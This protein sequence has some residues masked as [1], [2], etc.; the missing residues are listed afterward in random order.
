[1]P[2]VPP[3]LRASTPD[4]PD[5]PPLVQ[6]VVLRFR[7]A[8]LAWVETTLRRFVLLRCPAHPL[9]QIAQF[10]DPAPVVASC[11]AYYHADGTKGVP[12]TF[13]V[14]LLVRAEIV[15]SW[16]DSSSDRD[17][18]WHLISNLVV[19]WFVGLPL[20]SPAPDHSTLARLHAWLAIHHPDALFRDVL[21]FRDRVDP[22]AAATT[23]QIV[24]TLALQSPAAWS[25][26]VATLLLDL[27]ADLIVAWQHARASLQSAL[28]P[29]DFGPIIHPARPRDA[30]ERASLLVQAVILTQRLLAALTP[31][32]PAWPPEQRARITHLLSALAKVLADE[33]QLDASGYPTERT[34]KGDYRIISATD[35]EAT[36]RKH[37]DD[38]T[39]GYNV[40][41]ATTTTRIRAVVAVTGATPDNE[42]PILLA[43][44]QLLAQQP[45]PPYFIMDR[46]G[47]WGKCRARLD[48]VSNGQTQMVALIPPAGGA[49][50]TRFGPADF[51]VDPER[52]RCTCPNG[53]TS[54]KAYTRGDGDGVQFRFLASPCR[55]CPLW[56]DCCG[57][58]G[59]PKG[60]RSVFVSDDH[61]YL[62]QAAAFNQCVEGRALLASRWRVE[63]VIIERASRFEALGH[64]IALKG[65]GV[66]V[67]RQMGLESA[68]RARE[69]RFERS[70][71][72][73]AT[74]RLLRVGSQA[75]FDQNL[76]GYILFR[77][78]DLQAT[79]FEAVRDKLE[80]RY[81]TELVSLRDQGA[82]I[83]V[84][85]SVGTS[86][87]FDFVIGADG[88]HSRTRR[89]VFGDG[90]IEPLGGH[91][92]ALTV[93]FAHGLPANQVRSYFG[94][95]QS[96]HMFLTSPDH[97]STVVY[98]GAGGAQLAGKD[99]GSVKAF[100]LDAYN[101]FAPEVRAVF[102]AIDERAFVFVDAIGQVRMPS[103]VKGRVALIGDAAHCP[104]FMSGMGS[105]LALQGAQALA[106]HLEHQRDDP[107]RALR[108][109]QAAILPIAERYQASALEMRP[110]LLDRRPWLAWA[111]NAAL[112]LTPDW[113]MERKT[114]QF[115][116]AEH[117]AQ[118]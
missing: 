81:S 21:A 99:S 22:E 109:Y 87:S 8:I 80:I 67:I 104:T 38:L 11:A 62:R 57:V 27:C 4:L 31:H 32:L 46:A 113:L 98:H 76:G 56:N 73:T 92:I 6:Y 110:M 60:H 29:L 50:P 18:E 19:R 10:Y 61:A 88:I 43:A 68:C 39:L 86:E 20:L 34:E 28:P 36:F 84:E 75:E 14:D 37:D 65:N 107:A 44:Q 70:M 30:L 94:S 52:T 74:G 47:G 3:T 102:N 78:A 72:L 54:T 95:G 16:A 89:L 66:E 63:P 51:V 1:M 5:V 106:V 111:R 112:K 96:V 53:A 82:Q 41:I 116:Q 55:G 45:L 77:R 114:R 40:A 48:V 79:L 105:S 49:D 97:M 25:P 15:R 118:R 117:A 35:L 69:V 91:Y 108:S 71:M 58:E 23:P 2:I 64:Y 13:S 90:F 101:D 100:L 7:P 59:N 26:R 42:A 85:L 93:D 12:P 103:I 33:V 24:D 17:L 83:E 115:Y 9:I